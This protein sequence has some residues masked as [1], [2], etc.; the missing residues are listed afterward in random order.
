MSPPTDGRG[1]AFIHCRRLARLVLTRRKESSSMHLL[2]MARPDE[3]FQSNVTTGTWCAALCLRVK[4]EAFRA[5]FS[6]RA[7][8][9]R[10]GGHDRLDVLQGTSSFGGSSKDSLRQ[11]IG[12]TRGGLGTKMHAV[13]DA[14]GNPA[15]LCADNQGSATPASPSR[16]C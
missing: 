11:D 7:A 15:A 5:I 9:R 8:T 3:T 12:I 2:W 10:G 16:G 6:T 14:M 1:R 13:C 4:K